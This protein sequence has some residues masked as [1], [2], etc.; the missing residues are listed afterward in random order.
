M[1]I[2]LHVLTHTHTHTH[3]HILVDAVI[4]GRIIPGVT[5]GPTVSPFISNL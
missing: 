3:T 1:S 5:W 2:Y 4:W